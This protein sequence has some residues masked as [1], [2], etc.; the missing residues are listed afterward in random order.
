MPLI[1]KTNDRENTKKDQ[2]ISH[3]DETP[4]DFKARISKEEDIDKFDFG[5]V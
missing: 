4:E 2:W 5:E 1:A 3:Q